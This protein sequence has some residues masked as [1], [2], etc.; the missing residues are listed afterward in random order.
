MQVAIHN[1]T[2]IVCDRFFYSPPFSAS[3]STT[4]PDPPSSSGAFPAAQ[5]IL[6][7]TNQ[8]TA[9]AI[10]QLPPVSKPHPPSQTSDFLT[11]KTSD[12]KMQQQKQKNPTILNVKGPN[13]QQPAKR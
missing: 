12:W 4:S 2:R 8:R 6:D 11:R 13:R 10:A 9:A 1:K 3:S 5:L 7:E